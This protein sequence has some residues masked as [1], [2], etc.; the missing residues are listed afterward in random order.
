MK[1]CLLLIAFLGFFEISEVTAYNEV[2]IQKACRSEDGF[3]FCKQNNECLPRD[4]IFPKRCDQENITCNDDEFECRVNLIC[5][6][7][8]FL[9]TAEG[10]MEENKEWLILPCREEEYTCPNSRICLPRWKVRDNNM[11]CFSYKINDTS[12]EEAL[13]KCDLDKEFNCPISGRC[14][15]REWVMDGSN[16]C[17]DFNKTTPLS[18]DERLPF[19]SCDSKTEF[20]CPS[21]GRC[22]RRYRVRDGYNDCNDESDETR[23]LMTCT[24]DTE[25]Q[26]EDN[27][28]CIP[29]S[30]VLDGTKNCKDGSDEIPTVYEWCNSDE[31]LCHNTVRCIPLKYL[32]DGMNHCG[33]CSDEI[34]A[35]D[36]PRMWRCEDDDAVC[37]P[38]AYACDT[39]DDCPGGKDSPDRATG[40]RCKIQANG[41]EE[42]SCLIPQWM[43]HDS[44]AVCPDN[45]DACYDN[46]T[47]TCAYCVSDMTI[48]SKKQICDGMVDCADWSDECLC[49]NAI[50]GKDTKFE[51]ICNN[52]CFGRNETKSERCVR[53]EVYCPDDDK[54]IHQFLVCDNNEDCPISGFDEGSCQNITEVTSRNDSLND[55]ECEVYSDAIV[56]MFIR[57]QL[58]SFLTEINVHTAKRCDG[59]FEC[60]LFD[61]ECEAGC[62][63]VPE[64]CNTFLNRTM[65]WP[66]ELV[67]PDVGPIKSRICPGYNWED[68]Y[69]S[70]SFV[71]GK[72]IC[73]GISECPDGSDEISCK[74]RFYCDAGETLWPT[75]AKRVVSIEEKKY[76]DGVIDCVDFTDEDNC[77]SLTHF[78]CVGKE[79]LF[80]PMKSVL[81]GKRD[82]EDNSDEC[83]AFAFDDNP[84]S[85]RDEMISNSFLRYFIW[86]MAS[87]ALIGNASV[88]IETCYA[89]RKERQSSGLGVCNRIMLLN[90]AVSD[91]IMG[92][93]LVLIGIKSFQ[94][95]GEYCQEEKAWRTSL[96]CK[97][98]GVL[99]VLS[100]ETSVLILVALAYFRLKG[101]FWPLEARLLKKR[102]ALIASL[103]SWLVS[104]L[105]AVTPLIPITNQTMITD[106]LITFSQY[107]QSSTAN[108]K[109][110]ST[111][112]ARLSTMTNSTK[113]YSN[114]WKEVASVLEKH[115][116]QYD[117]PHIIGYFGFFSAH[118]VCLPRLFRITNAPPLHVFS[119]FIITINFLCLL[120]IILFY[121][122]IYH[123][124]M[125]TRRSVENLGSA[126]D[127]RSK[128]LQRKITILIATDVCCWLPIC[129]MTFVSHNGIWITGEVY[130]VSAIVLLPINSSLN[131][132]I[133]SNILSSRL[134][135]IRLSFARFTNRYS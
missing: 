55:F 44:N 116:S 95:S 12:D 56:A 17:S 5:V 78:Y 39:Y 128:I 9:N 71:V 40:F 130:A 29:R 47:F 89:E 54:C 123:E 49:M 33:D 42:V 120:I 127:D 59:V 105:F 83:P 99:T 35:C 124:Y 67:G 113:Y 110:L 37:I 117:V 41:L 21:S 63:N 115:G 77:S 52:V 8:E 57:F 107:F 43:L 135:A 18:S 133:Y 112:A 102:V 62:D 97:L 64:I 58:F 38:H 13:L 66:P 53:N 79:P 28:R 61:D 81:D 19:I 30:W 50:N 74:G 15:P 82:C 106:A 11:D 132:I 24:N 104:F 7:R 92:I 88:I 90:L 91:L 27:G 70:L 118:G 23:D 76:C 1:S 25:F 68:P 94:F 26:C 60:V 65:E 96:L 72:S 114:T 3:H 6:R 93:A 31:F 45:S 125:R 103:C 109:E 46:R 85:S 119:L 86:V 111:F 80:V 2:S 16:D 101:V 32:C 34:E 126:G 131:P 51:S 36:E 20:R 22:L 75:G 129:I 48:I 84:F 121:L 73:N 100:S 4:L 87:L 108:W 134:N 69:G 122:L 14:I 10:C 98:I